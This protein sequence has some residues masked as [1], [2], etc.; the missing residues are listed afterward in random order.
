MSRGEFAEALKVSGQIE[1][2]P[3][4]QSVISAPTSGILRLTQKGLSVGSRVSAGARVG[5][6]DSRG[7]AG[8]DPNAG[9]R[10]AV[11]SARR[12]L[13]RITPLY[14]E[15]LASAKEYNDARAAYENRAGRL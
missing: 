13:D 9:A 8:G 1:P 12:E 10:T 5:S 7:V 4:D 15:G 2:A 11:E 6:I 14:K 3:M